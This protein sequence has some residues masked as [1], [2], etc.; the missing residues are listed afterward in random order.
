MWYQ[1]YLER[2]VES[3]IRELVSKLR[4]VVREQEVLD[5]L[6][7]EVVVVLKRGRGRQKR[8]KK[9]HSRQL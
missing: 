4:G 6:Y 3:I 9:V 8:G 1:D 7:K 2:E 5:E